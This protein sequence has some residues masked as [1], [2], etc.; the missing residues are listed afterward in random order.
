MSFTYEYARPALTVDAVLFGLDTTDLKILLIRRGL[1]PFK[2]KWSLP[3]GFVRIGESPDDSV[4]REL[5]EETGVK[6]KRLVQLGAYGAPGRDPREHVVS[7]AFLGLTPVCDHKPAADTDA[8]AV[9]WHPI[10]DLPSLAF[11]HATM[12]EDAI[13]KLRAEASNW[14]LGRDLLPAKF[15]LR[16]LQ[17]LHERILDRPLDKRNFRREALASGLLEELEEWESDVSHRAARL[18]RFI[19]RKRA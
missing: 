5:A 2:G 6:V 8:E 1:E 11:D 7:I 15:T 17:T 9:A 18:F 19:K 14:E 12:V 10:D 16:E 3:G 4:A 13:E